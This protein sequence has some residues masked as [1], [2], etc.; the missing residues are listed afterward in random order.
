MFPQEHFPLYKLFLSLRYLRKRPI[1]L[2]SVIGV[3]FGVLTLLV[4]TSVMGGFARDLRARIRGMSAHITVTSSQFSRLGSME[5]WEELAKRVKAAA[6]DEVLAVSPQLEW[7]IMISKGQT[8]QPA[9]LV[10]IIPDLEAQVS[11]FSEHMLDGHPPDFTD[12]SGRKM[13]EG[14]GPCIMGSGIL[15]THRNKDIVFIA[16]GPGAAAAAASCLPAVNPKDKFAVFVGDQSSSG[17]LLA[18]GD[19]RESHPTAAWFNGRADASVKNWPDVLERIF[20]LLAYDTVGETRPCV[21]V[22]LGKEMPP[23]GA[24]RD[25]WYRLSTEARRLL[26]VYTP[27]ETLSEPGGE[28]ARAAQFLRL[29][30][31]PDA[32]LEL[33]SRVQDPYI[34]TGVSITTIAPADARD[35]GGLDKRLDP[36]H[37]KL[38]IVGAFN[39]GMNEY[40]SQVIYAPLEYVQEALRECLVDAKTKEP[41]LK[42]GRIQGGRFNKLRIKIRNY[43]DAEKVADRIRAGLKGSYGIFTWQSEKAILLQAVAV[44]RTLTGVI[45]FFIVIMAAFSILA[46]LSMLVTEKTRDIGIL[47]AQGATVGGIMTIFLSEGAVI[48]L[49]GCGLG[50]GSAKYVLDHLNPLADWVYGKTGWYPFPKNIYLLDRIP[51]QVDGPIWALVVGA[52]LFVCLLAALWPSWKAARLNP[53]DALRYE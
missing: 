4:V 15:T 48:G 26:R 28:K 53:I 1:S 34:G 30:P 5:N 16:D 29:E 7:P 22:L 23:E 43:D 46:I 25:A 42:D 32:R 13:P 38:G 9:T 52:T 14:W 36:T 33:V 11:G 39:S 35:S 47:R 10:G 44:E 45:M 27:G 20:R 8:P 41:V 21:V 51:H 24:F 37:S 17:D 2:L 6:P 18:G 19:E 31:G 49:V 3:W 40:D 50:L 12:F